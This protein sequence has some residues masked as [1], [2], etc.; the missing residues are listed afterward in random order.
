M[1][2]PY[3]L[4]LSSIPSVSLL[5]FMNSQD[6]FLHPLCFHFI[7]PHFDTDNITLLDLFTLHNGW[8]ANKV[9]ME[10]KGKTNMKKTY[11]E[12][13]GKKRKRGETHSK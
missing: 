1:R 12:V 10:N 8:I 11:K 3:V 6:H 9:T 2:S 4:L 5:S 13:R 7:L